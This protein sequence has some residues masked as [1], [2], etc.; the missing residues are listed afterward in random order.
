MSGGAARSRKLPLTPP[1]LE[2]IAYLPFGKILFAGSRFSWSRP[3]LGKPKAAE[4]FI[5]FFLFPCNQV[6]WTQ[7]TPLIEILFKG[8]CDLNS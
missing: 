7:S 6:A 2:G 3:G 8:S 5:V 1:V 4:C